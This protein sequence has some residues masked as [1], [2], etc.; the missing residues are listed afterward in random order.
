MGQRTFKSREQTKQNI[1]KNPQ[2]STFY[3][4]KLW[5]EREVKH[6]TELR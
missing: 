3:F 4:R 1:K 5:E 6:K 2:K